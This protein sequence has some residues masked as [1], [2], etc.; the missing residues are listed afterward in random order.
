MAAEAS[1]GKALSAVTSGK[2]TP[3][4][5][6]SQRAFALFVGAMGLLSLHL[7]R[8]AQLQLVQGQYNRTL[9]ENNRIRRSPMVADRGNIL[10]RH[11]KLLVGNKLTRSVYLYPREQT[12]EEWQ[13]TAQY[14]GRIL[15]LD[16]QKILAKIETAGYRS[17]MPVR[18]LRDIKADVFTAM[19]ETGYIPGVEI[20]PESNRIYP[21]K[22]LGSHLLGYIGEAS[23]TQL[24]DNPKWPMGMLVGQMGL[25]RLADDQLRGEW[26]N[27]LFEVDASGRELRMLGIQ[28]PKSGQTLKTT[29]DLAL[30][31]AAEQGLAG[32]RGAVVVLDV[33][34]GGIMAMASG[35]TFDPNM[36]TRRITQQEVNEVFNNP[37]KPL[38]N[39]ALQGYPPASTFKIVSSVAG[40]ESGKYSP[41]S[42]IMTSGA[43]NIGGTLFHEHSGGGYG[44]I[45]FKT[46]LQVS[47]NTFFYQ[48]GPKIGSHEI[49]KWSHK[50]GIG[51][52][53][54][55]LDGE[56]KGLIPTPEIKQE[57]TGE[58][59]YVGDE[60]T[61]AIGQG[62][63]TVT[64]M[65]LAV[66]LA[67]IAN[68]GKRVKPHFLLSQSAEQ[69]FQPVAIGLKPSTIKT[70]QAGLELVVTDGTARS[71]N[72]GS[73]PRTAGKTGTAEVPGGEDNSMF[74]GYGPVNNP[75]IAIA[76]VVERGGYG[77][78]AAVPIAHA[79]YKAY[80][81]QQQSK[82][83]PQGI[84]ATQP[85][86]ASVAQR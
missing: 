37:N 45:G 40:L 55:F 50:L 67:A 14:L 51:E 71:L 74:V 53:T 30:Q 84:Q 66:V 76:V 79:V 33:E 23:E 16:P 60:V 38:L 54:T 21:H 77:S 52:T 31:K 83:Q 19:A 48:L 6:R 81:A 72:D 49:Y 47:S 75:K 2:L 8:L 68:G 43:V 27:R 44:A 65:E 69:E 32:R 15:K 28:R 86:P 26:G 18:I 34:T 80:F 25:E 7:F 61:M 11:G 56:S 13:D 9:A 4:A 62:M 82:P 1:V 29:L 58:P 63:V 5:V 36:F 20:Q 78:T 24:R 57:L 85:Q 59:W 64:P 42:T 10:D 46:A 3:R 12:R 41:S 17:R 22:K 70:V 39:R 35:P 73:I